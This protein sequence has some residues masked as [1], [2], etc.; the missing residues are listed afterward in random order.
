VRHIGTSQSERGGSPGTAPACRLRGCPSRQRR[1]VGCVVMEADDLGARTV[2]EPYGSRRLGVALFGCNVLVNRLVSANW[3]VT[4]APNLPSH[5]T[6]PRSAWAAL[7]GRVGLG[8]PDG[9]GLATVA[10]NGR[11]SVV[12]TSTAEVRDR[13]RIALAA[14]ARACRLLD[15]PPLS[16]P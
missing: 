13:A 9:N 11:V 15:S 1:G 3:P 7:G 5:R 16:W 2:R 14:S 6:T 10:T 4:E 8:L 12:V